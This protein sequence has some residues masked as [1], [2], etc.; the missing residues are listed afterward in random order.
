MLEAPVPLPGIQSP[1][2]PFLGDNKP[3]AKRS[4]GFE[5]MALSLDGKRLYPLLE[6]ALVDHP[7]KHLNI[8]EFDPISGKYAD[9]RPVR[10]YK[11]EPEGKAATEF[12][13]LTENKYLIIERDDGEGET[14]RFKKIYLVD[15][16]VIDSA[17]FLAK[18]SWLIY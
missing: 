1:H 9:D 14:A 8:Y 4:A 12:I 16:D 11:L 7:E 15:F 18:K 5:G 13:A 3:N 17:G 6:K 10:K 2:N